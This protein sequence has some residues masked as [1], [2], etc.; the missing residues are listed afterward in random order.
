MCDNFFD[1]WEEFTEM[2]YSNNLEISED[3]DKIRDKWHESKF[4]VEY[5]VKHFT[6]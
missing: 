5:G 1:W 4:S 6:R 3:K 2:A